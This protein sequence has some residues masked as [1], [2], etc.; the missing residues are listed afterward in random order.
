MPLALKTC[1]KLSTDWDRVSCTGGVFMENLQTSYGTK[2]Q[3]L[4]D[5]D[6][7]YPCPTVAEHQKLYCYLMVTSR[8]L[9]VVDGSW[10]KTVAW[11]R[12]AE[13]NW[14]ATCFQSLGR[15]ASGRT[16]QNPKKILAI[17]AKG[18]SMA[19]ECI[20]GAARDITSMDAGA[21]RS[22]GFCSQAPANRRA[23]CFNGIGTILGG[24]SRDSAPRKAACR[25]AVPKA[26]WAD[27]FAG[28][29]A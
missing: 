1:D 13:S 26:Y 16:L 24:F 27:C 23:Y 18:G 12:K 22:T 3:W 6:P 28:A 11:C 10:D 5:D 4:K 21:R 25:A 2:S 14:I 7:L 17:C 9:D 15:D 19:R 20:Y 8:I 29:R